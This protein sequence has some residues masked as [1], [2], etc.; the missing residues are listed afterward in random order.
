MMAQI[1]L[2]GRLNGAQRNRLKGLLNMEYTPREL[3]EEIGM[4]HSQVYRVYL[5]LGCPMRRDKKGHIWINGQ[6]FRKWYEVHYQKVEM[7]I[8]EAFCLSCKRAVQIVD[9]EVRRKNG[10][11]FVMSACPRCGRR[12]ARI[13]HRI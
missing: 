5:S 2:K 6:G 7:G 12:L 1:E 3:G 8:D 9:P 11:E 4:N 13:A 10:L